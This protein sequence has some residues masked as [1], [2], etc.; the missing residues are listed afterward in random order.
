MDGLIEVT[1]T[2]AFVAPLHWAI[3]RWFDRLDS[4][5]YLRECGVVILDLRALDAL[6]RVIGSFA[7]A[8]LHGS[9]VFK[10]LVYDFDRPVPRAYRRRIDRDE[11]YL[12]P[13]LLYLASPHGG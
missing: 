13:G 1:A 8:P 4:A 12:D 6:G 7:G 11:L 9:V 2:F 10:G 3:L 5:A